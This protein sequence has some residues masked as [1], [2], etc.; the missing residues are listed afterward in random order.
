MT[1]LPR[2]VWPV[3]LAA[4]S[5]LWLVSCGGGGGGE[6]PANGLSG[7]VSRLDTGDP[8]G[9]VTVQVIPNGPSCQSAADGAFRFDNLPGAY[10]RISF[11]R[12][13]YQPRYLDF[14]GVGSY[15]EVELVHVGAG[16]VN[17]QV[18]DAEG[19]PV[20]GARVEI[21]GVAQSATTDASGRY[22]LYDA[23]GGLQTLQGA[24]I[25]YK[26]Q[27]VD[28]KIADGALV[29]RNLQL[30]RSAA[31]SWLTGTIRDAVTH[32]IIAGATLW[33]GTRRAISDQ[34]GV[35]ALYE[36]REGGYDLTVSAP[37]YR[38]ATLANPLQVNLG[39]NVYSVT[40]LPDG[41]I[42]PPPPAN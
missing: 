38:T 31:Q 7:L 16:Q 15:L 29:S 27:T 42:E 18:Y 3:L 17:G 25:G 10:T 23:P 1:R 8:L 32:E 12:T 9:G 40:L 11:S 41:Y 6:T 13:G 28:V 36:L 20:S 14:P 37:G 33:L 24:A 22:W 5:G 4:A 35:Y 34:N 39:A 21:V 26:V 2:I 19:R 30:D